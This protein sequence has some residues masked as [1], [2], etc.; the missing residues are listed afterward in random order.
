MGFV[1]L[2]TG[3]ESSEVVLEV[4]LVD[5]SG[6][7]RATD[8]VPALTPYL[9]RSSEAF[10]AARFPD[11]SSGTD[12]RVK[13]VSSRPAPQAIE[14]LVGS[15]VVTAWLPG[16]GLSLVGWLE[17]TSRR[18]IAPT[19]LVVV[20][21]DVEGLPRASAEGAFMPP[22]IRPGEL[23][24]F[25]SDVLRPDQVHEW[26][27]LAHGL[28]PVYP[29][30]ETVTLD[31][32]LAVR[33]DPQGRPF[34]VGRIVNGSETPR[35]ARV[36]ILVTMEDE[37][38]SLGVF[39]TLTSLPPRSTLPFVIDDFP[40]LEER[41]AAGEADWDDLNVEAFVNEIESDAAVIQLETEITAYEVIGSRLYL[42]GQ[43]RN[44]G[45]STIAAAAVVAGVLGD[46]GELL[47]AGWAAPA[48]RLV[49]GSQA[50]FLL[51][52]PVPKGADLTLAEY[53]VRA[54]GVAD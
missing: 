52:M 2:V 32:E 13:V 4:S 18:P 25:R 17:N 46:G 38:L 35:S 22:V 37:W 41:L 31:G 1:S 16:G 45:A 8:V 33:Q 26:M 34:A 23:L 54:F 9:L 24:P 29:R 36:G 21:L 51:V 47:T 43:I 20:G 7:A 10:F 30:P 6:A 42:R 28:P 40:G 5:K 44:E 15:I 14:T 27:I 3:P 50:D 39:E 12:L 49:P 53:D 19:G 11:G 48:E